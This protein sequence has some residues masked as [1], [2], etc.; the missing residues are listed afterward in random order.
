M[1]LSEEG[2]SD[3]VTQDP[4]RNRKCKTRDWRENEREAKEQKATFTP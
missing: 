3:R 4:E 2:Q 1:R